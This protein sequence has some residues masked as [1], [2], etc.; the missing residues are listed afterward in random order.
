MARETIVNQMV[1]ILSC[2]PN[3]AMLEALSTLA[4]AKSLEEQMV[5]YDYWIS[6]L[7]QKPKIQPL[8]QSPE[9][10]EFF[11]ANYALA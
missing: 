10:I 2:G 1:L 5:P 9:S 4:V 11:A 7:M 3:F 6:P 8:I